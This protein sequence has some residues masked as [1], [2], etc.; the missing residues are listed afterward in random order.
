MVDLSRYVVMDTESGTFFSAEH[1][2][3]IDTTDLNPEEL[4][5]LNEGTDTERAL[6]ADIYG[7]CIAFIP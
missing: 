1:A 3:V 4:D 2:C 7:K 6:L 5:A